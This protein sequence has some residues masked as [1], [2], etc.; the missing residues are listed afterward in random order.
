MLRGL[1]QKGEIHMDMQMILWAV[2][3]VL[4]VVIELCSMQLISIWF[5]VGALAAFAS[6]FKLPFVGQ[7]TVFVI[8]TA[9]MLL[10][11]RPLLKKL[12]KPAV[13]TNHEL[14]L[15]KT[16]LVIEDINASAGTGRVRV[17]G[18]DWSASTKDGS[19]IKSGETVKVVEVGGAR[20]TV[21]KTA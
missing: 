11:T 2:I 7:L 19:T 16:A 12:R 1:K 3:F 13:P 18:I 9:V 8:V 17:Q 14:D 10:A 21:E 4:A 6:S 15:G 5:A 20:L